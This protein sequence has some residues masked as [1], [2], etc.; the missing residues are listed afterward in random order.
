MLIGELQKA[1]KLVQLVS[2][3]ISISDLFKCVE[4]SSTSLRACSEFGNV[5]YAISMPEITAPKLV[6]TAAFFAVINNLATSGEI[7]F[8]L[9]ETHLEWK[10]GSAKGKW[11]FAAVDGTIPE[12]THTEF[13]W[14]P[15][16]FF[17]DALILA[18]G[19]CQS[20]TVSVGLYG[21]NIEPKDG[22]L[23]L[24]SSN[25]ISLAIAYVGL[26]GYP[27]TDAITVRPPIPRILSTLIKTTTN[28]R[29]DVTDDGFYFTSDE[30]I[31]QLPRS[32]PLE[33]DLDGVLSKFSTAV[34]TI[35]ISNAAIAQF[36]NRAK[37]LAD[38]GVA[39]EISFRITNGSIVLE[40]K[41]ISN[42]SEE[43]FLAEGIDATKEFNSVVLPINLMVD[44]LKNVDEAILDYL[45][46]NVL[47]LRGVAPEFMHIIG[48]KSV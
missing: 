22:K 47:V 42:T 23:R 6:N 36:L 13:P 21:M 37:A 34:D 43:Y 28:G 3:V 10:A 39:P 11:A 32:V 44:A 41:G 14:V 38:K 48:G 33:H 20:A 25:M 30:V 24:V 1:A 8:K 26:D 29:L 18:S 12:I 7:H 9:T 27:K 46:N 40:Q 19:A 5:K 31:A 35:P 4:L 2:N 15:S 16:E 17:A 45:P